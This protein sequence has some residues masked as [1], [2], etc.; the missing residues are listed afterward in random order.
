MKI[1]IIG[2]S[3]FVGGALVEEAL[4]RSHEVTAIVRNTDRLSKREHL[5]A[6]A[7]DVTNTARLAESLR[8]HDA[9]ISAF[10]GGTAGTD[11]YE[12]HVRGFESI[13]KAAKL[14]DVPRLLVVGGAGSLEVA[15]GVQ[16]VDSP[17]F[18][19]EWKAN[20]LATRQALSV[21]RQE[22]SLHWTFLSPPAHLEPGERR[23]VYRTGADA[24]LTDAAGSS[25]ISVA[26]YAMSMIDELE[27]PRHDRRRFTVA[28]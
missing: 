8:G 12:R 15:P 18:P 19:A 1:A 28:Y 25:H 20:A 21:L 10:S 7:V 27:Q 23:G 6:V 26:D 24:L 11:A 4:S 9:V 13:L 22:P 2:A 3:G 5:R 17:Q 16:V 14:A